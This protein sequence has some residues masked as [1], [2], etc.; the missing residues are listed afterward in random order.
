MNNKK[1]TIKIQTPKGRPFLRWV[2]KAPLDHVEGHPTQLV[3][4]YAPDK[5]QFGQ[6]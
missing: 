3:E 5:K 2:G 4:Y 6:D 1:R